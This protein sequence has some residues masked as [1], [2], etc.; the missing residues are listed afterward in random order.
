MSNRQYRSLIRNAYSVVTWWTWESQILQSVSGVIPWLIMS[1][2]S[3]AF[4]AVQEDLTWLEQG[5][6]EYENE[7]DVGY[8]REYIRGQANFAD[9]ELDLSDDECSSR[10]MKL[11]HQA[12]HGA[13]SQVFPWGCAAMFLRVSDEHHCYSSVDL[14][15]TNWK[16]V[17]CFYPWSWL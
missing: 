4:R 3:L 8:V 11:Y 17:W 12:L 15:W 6:D 2:S 7:F 10:S 5:I 14:C 13:S 16:W 1:C 9:A